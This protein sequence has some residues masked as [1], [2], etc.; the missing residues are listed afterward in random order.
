MRSMLCCARW[1]AL[2]AHYAGSRRCRLVRASASLDHACAARRGLAVVRVSWPDG[3]SPGARLAVMDALSELLQAIRLDSAIYFHAELSEPW[4][5]TSPDSRLLAPILAHGGGHVIIYHLICDGGAYVQPQDGDRVVLSAGD[6]VTFP[7]GDSHLLGSGNASQPI[8]VRAA[9]PGVLER[10]L[11]LLH[12]GGGGARSR[13]ICG[14]LSCDPELGQAFLGGLPPLIKI[15]IREEPS[16]QWLE[17]SLQFSVTQ[18]A[19][20]EAGGDAM[21]AKLS[22]AVFAETLRRYVRHLPE[23]EIGW[24]AGARDAGVGRALTLLHRRYADRWTLAALA[25]AVGVSRTVLTERFHHFLGE[26]PMTYLTRWRL[27]LGARAL[28]T[29]SRTVAQIAFENGY[30]SEASFNRAFKRE[31]GVPPAR[32]RKIKRRVPTPA[33]D[34]ADEAPVPEH[35]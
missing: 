32:Y 23:D 28:M 25:R 24:L 2:R 14:F 29:T 26:P 16:G 34:G 12:V 33:P 6:I 4:C 13:L 21:L 1:R 8:D 18:A 30:E 9:L 10:G 11:E 19:R 35:A 3:W 15:N 20:R 27:R 31:Y 22:E 5:L 17:N 7:H